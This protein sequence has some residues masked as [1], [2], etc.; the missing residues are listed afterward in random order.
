MP[1]CVCWVRKEGGEMGIKTASQSQKTAHFLG[2]V[3]GVGN[4]GERGMT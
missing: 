3:E 4:G 2:G 1:V